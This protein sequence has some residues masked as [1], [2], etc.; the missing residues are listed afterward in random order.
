MKLLN[1]KYVLLSYFDEHIFTITW[2]DR[3]ELRLLA[4][5]QIPWWNVVGG[6]PTLCFLPSV[7]LSLATGAAQLHV[8]QAH[9]TCPQ[10]ATLWA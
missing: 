8:P 4:S 5:L 6:W 10:T 7:T 2:K 9:F 3:F 1:K